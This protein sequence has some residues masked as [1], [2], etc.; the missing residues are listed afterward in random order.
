MLLRYSAI[1]QPWMGCGTPPLSL[2]PPQPSLFSRKHKAC[3]G[4]GIG[5]GWNLFFYR[6]ALTRILGVPR[7]PPWG[8]G[9]ASVDRSDPSGGFFPRKTPARSRLSARSSSCP[10]NRPSFPQDRGTPTPLLS[11]TRRLIMSLS[12]PRECFFFALV[13]PT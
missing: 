8:P 4:G 11:S 13:A 2:I 7:S 5:F 9:R 10:R 12:A 3:E 6:F 1:A